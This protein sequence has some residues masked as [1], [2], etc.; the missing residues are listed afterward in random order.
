MP[1]PS[2]TRTLEVPCRQ[3]SNPDPQSFLL[4]VLQTLNAWLLNAWLLFGVLEAQPHPSEGLFVCH[5]TR[6]VES[7]SKMAG[8]ALV[9]G[10]QGYP[11]ADARA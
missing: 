6:C 10:F 1:K 7:R 9:L 11:G 3:S 8:D 5:A 4:H 2:K